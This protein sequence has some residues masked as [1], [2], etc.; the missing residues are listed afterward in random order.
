[1]KYTVSTDGRTSLMVI[2]MDLAEA[3]TKSNG[4]A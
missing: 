2:S 3:L 4:L 1:M